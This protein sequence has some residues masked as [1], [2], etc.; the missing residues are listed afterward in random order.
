MR[1]TVISNLVHELHRVLLDAADGRFPD[2]DGAVEILEPMA[3]D[4]HGVVEFTGHSFVLTDLEVSVEVFAAKARG[5]GRRLIGESLALIP[6]GENVFARI[7]PGNVASLKAFLSCG[8]TPIGAERLL[9]PDP[10]L[11]HPMLGSDTELEHD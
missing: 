3:G 8:F 7:A 9:H 4:H 2:V 1:W 11:T 5:S 10:E 6:R